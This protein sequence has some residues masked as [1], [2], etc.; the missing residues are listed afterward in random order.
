LTDG[1]HGELTVSVDGRQV[2]QKGETLP[3]LDE[4]VHT[5]KGALATAAR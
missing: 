3:S 1:Q 5:V 2:F 4:V